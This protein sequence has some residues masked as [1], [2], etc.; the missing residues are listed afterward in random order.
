[1]RYLA[2]YLNWEKK[3]KEYFKSSRGYNL[4][5]HYTAP[6][7]S[8]PATVVF[9]GGF[10]SDMEG[11]K[12]TGFESLCAARGQGYLRF[13][14]SGHGQSDQDFTDGTI[15]QWAEDAFDIISSVT[16]G[17]LVL[18]GS[19]MGGWISLL[20][21]PRLANRVK[22]FIGIAAAPDFIKDMLNSSISDDQ[23]KELDEK[24]IFYMP[25]DYDVPYPITKQLVEDGKI[26]CIL[27]QPID[28]NIP[29]RLLQGTEDTAVADEKP[30]LIKQA[31]TTQDIEIEWFEGGNHS[32]SRPEDIERIDKHIQSLS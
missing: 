23:L 26:Q 14:Y 16:K 15:G 25:S 4:A 9:L 8:N 6:E 32:L 19:S 10:M 11:S 17:P 24:G 7:D 31:L 20:I 29:V 27:D 5:Y 2:K 12:A 3:M 22:G 21:A 28:L 18:V 30:E 13:D 1:M